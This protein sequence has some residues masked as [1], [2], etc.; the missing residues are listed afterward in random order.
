GEA[1]LAAAAQDAQ[2]E[3]RKPRPANHRDDRRLQD[4][5]A[6]QEAE[7]ERECRNC[8]GDS[9]KPAE[10]ERQSGLQYEPVHGLEPEAVVAAAGEPA[11]LAQL[12]QQVL[13]VGLCAKQLKPAIDV[14]AIRRAG[15]EEQ[16]E[17][18]DQE[19]NR[20]R[21][22]EI[23]QVNGIELEGHRQASQRLRWVEI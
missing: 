9:S 3:I 20:D 10:P 5:T 22:K 6:K 1:G 12:H 15:K 2:H 19:S 11:L 13:P 7:S 21:D 16:I 4:I 17:T 14:L 8:D 23:D 18:L